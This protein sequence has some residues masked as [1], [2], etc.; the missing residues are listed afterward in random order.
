M[1]TDTL[2]S[3]ASARLAPGVVSGQDYQT[4]L[5]ACRIGRYALPA[6]N[7]CSTDTANAVL[8]AA[9]RNRSDV[10]LQVSNGGAR[11][12]GGPSLPDSHRARVL[13]ALSL[14]RHVHIMA[15]EYGVAVILH[16][17]H[18]DR[19][20]LRW[21]DDLI[22]FSEAEFTQTGRPLFSSHM[23]DLSTEPF[24]ENMRESER[25]LRRLTPLGMGLEIEL[26]ITG[27][28][29]DGI[30]DSRNENG[31]PADETQLYTR[32]EEVFE[33]WK[34]LSPLGALSIAAS[35]GNVHGVYAPG[36]VQLRPGLL[37]EAQKLVQQ[38]AHDGPNPLHL[39]FHG[40]SGT[41][42]DQIREAVS[43][44]V[45]KFNIDTDTQFAFAQ[46]AAKAIN[47]HE[48]AF[49]HQVNPYTGQPLKRFYDPREWL[50]SAQL[51]CVSRLDRTFEILGARGR[52]LCRTP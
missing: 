46:G 18:A 38:H 17:D 25:F 9:A 1:K 21:V 45:F 3:P 51:S 39:V 16:T 31:L 42:L 49:Q 32:P 15:R 50:R 43:Y 36:N 14:A 11:F 23:L 8:E 24:E 28:E 5:Q 29:E 19:S 34:R 37:K 35:F 4:L 48:M 52:S 10:I 41:D 40:G 2:P 47:A 6:V 27:G 44:G 20:L 12:Y 33:A 30:G 7:V 26:G 22:G 13:G